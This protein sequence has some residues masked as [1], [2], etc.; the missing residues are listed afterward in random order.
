MT[1]N[2]PEQPADKQGFKDTAASPNGQVMLVAEDEPL[3]LSSGQ[4]LGPIEVAYCTWGK[5]NEDRSNAI[6]VCHAFSGNHHAAG[7]ATA[8]KAAGWWDQLIG[9]NKAIDTNKYFVVSSNNIG[10]RCS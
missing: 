10:G 8:N 5:L 3:V 1:K 9:P 4:T 6:L 2:M 7:E